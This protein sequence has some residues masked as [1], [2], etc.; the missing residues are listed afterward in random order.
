M[1]RIVK[2]AF[3]PPFDIGRDV[4]ELGT[5]EILRHPTRAL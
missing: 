4:A 2:A 1:Q 5:L 3:G